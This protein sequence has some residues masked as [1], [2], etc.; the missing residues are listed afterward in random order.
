MRGFSTI[1]LLVALMLLSTLLTVAL[2]LAYGAP[3]L[4][5]SSREHD[6]ALAYAEAA[7]MRAERAHASHFSSYATTSASARYTVGLVAALLPDMTTMR[8]IA[9]TSWIGTGGTP[10]DVSLTSYVTDYRN[11][12]TYPCDIL[13]RG[14][15]RIPQSEVFT[16]EPGGLLPDDLALESVRV[17]DLA[18]TRTHLVATSERTMSGNDP[19]LFLF[20]LADDAPI[21]LASLPL[22]STTAA[23]ADVALTRTHA[24]VASAS[25]CAN[26]ARCGQL[27]IVDLGNPRDPRL[28]SQLLLPPDAPPHASDGSGPVAAASIAH[29]A[30]TVY[31]GLEQT[32]APGNEFVTISV[33]NPARPALVSSIRIGRTVNDIE[34]WGDR[35]YLATNARATADIRVLDITDPSQFLDAGSLALP[36]LQSSS[37]FGYAH[38]LALYLDELHVGRTYISNADEWIVADASDAALPIRASQN[39]GT[40][41]DPASVRAV[42]LREGQ[43]VIVTSRALTIWARSGPFHT[44]PIASVPIIGAATDATCVGNDIYVSSMDGATGILTRVTAL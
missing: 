39:L 13:P 36:P 9:R 19:S 16:L 41:H 5:A 26:P 33:D 1:E 44:L 34:L 2:L 31:L 25:T 42:I 40:V 43:A 22:S 11:P 24:Y 6:A 3:T 15:W 35:A 21:Y 27:K 20:S 23:I 38:V 18:A 4:L 8:L 12:G 17:D 32:V 30:D 29:R 10:R 7:L 14:D 37:R 28:I